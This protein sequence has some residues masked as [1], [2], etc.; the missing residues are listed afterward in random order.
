MEKE[1]EREREN[2]PRKCSK[3]PNFCFLFFVF[4]LFCF[5]FFLF[6]LS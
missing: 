6:F 4:F 2:L 1:K 3:M 5:V